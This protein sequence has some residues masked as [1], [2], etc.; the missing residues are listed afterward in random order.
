LGQLKCFDISLYLQECASS[1]RRI[2]PSSCP[3]NS[4]TPET[5][6]INAYPCSS[7]NLAAEDTDDSDCEVFRVK[8]RSGITPDRRRTEDATI[9]SFTENQVQIFR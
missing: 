4:F 5:A 1:N 9:T 3:E 2:F 7:E 8:R 6:K